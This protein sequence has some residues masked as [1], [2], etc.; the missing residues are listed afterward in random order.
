MAQHTVNVGHTSTCH[1]QLAIH[2]AYVA[3]VL[4]EGI[5]EFVFK[6]SYQ[7][8]MVLFEGMEQFLKKHLCNKR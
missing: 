1:L 4:F 7:G 3:L 6:Y 5:P 2:I 8:T